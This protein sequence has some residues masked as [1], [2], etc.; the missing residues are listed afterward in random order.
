VTVATTVTADGRTISLVAQDS[1][2]GLCLKLVG[3]PDL[4]RP[5]CSPPPARAWF[6]AANGVLPG[7]FD[8][9]PV[10]TTYFAGAVT[11][12]TAALQLLLR[13]GRS[14][15]FTTVDG[16]YSGRY[17]GNVR[18]FLGTEPGLTQPYYSRA[19]DSAGKVRAAFEDESVVRPYRGPVVV[20]RGRLA[21]HR[22]HVLAELKRV[23]DPSAGQPE[24][25]RPA[26]C[27]ALRRSGGIFPGEPRTFDCDPLPGAGALQVNYGTDSGGKGCPVGPDV[28][29]YGTARR[30]IAR[31]EL[32]LSDGSTLRAPVR[33]PPRS[34]GISR[35]LFAAA[36]ASAAPPVEVDAFGRSG[37]R[38]AH[39]HVPG[40]G[41]HLPKGGCSG[42][43][44]F[45]GG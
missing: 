32:R 42:S 23:L 21:G 40:S 44:G 37:T 41:Q 4:Q 28:F 30:S 7:G 5:N 26:L 27:M 9:D 3:I 15:T 43:F 39:S 20:A 2:Q 38:V 45:F 14:A 17:K 24:Q 18:F 10:P 36:S 22:Y 6:D 33:S 16:G 11:P 34:L 1:N 13:G 8:A 31:V 12:G 25:R 19:L 35:G 29:I